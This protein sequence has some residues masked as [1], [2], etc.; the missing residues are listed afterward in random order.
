MSAQNVWYATGNSNNEGV[1]RSVRPREVGMTIQ[2]ALNKIN[3]IKHP[4]SLVGNR[5][6][7]LR[8]ELMY[9]KVIESLVEDKIR[10]LEN[11]IKTLNGGRRKTYKSRRTRHN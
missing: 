10:G 2:E 7:S 8:E 11:D 1:Y 4:M 6:D 5:G 9:Y 3:S